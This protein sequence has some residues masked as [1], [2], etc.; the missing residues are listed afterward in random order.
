[1]INQYDVLEKTMHQREKENYI[2]DMLVRTLY[3]NDVNN[4]ESQRIIK[5]FQEKVFGKE[6]KTIY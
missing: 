6:Q 4:S 1:M 5:L 2:A 3:C